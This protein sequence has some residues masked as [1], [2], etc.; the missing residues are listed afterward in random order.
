MGYEI[1]V[2]EAP[3][4]PTAVVALSTT[5]PDLPAEAGDA[6]DEV[7]DFL[8]R[9]EGLRFDGHNVI[10]YKDGQPNVEV[11]VIVTGPFP[12]EG[13]VQASVLPAAKV[14]RTVHRGGYDKLAEAH[15]AGREWCEAEGH[16][17]V[18]PRWEIYG[19]W[20]DEN[21]EAVETEVCWQL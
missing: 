10:L 8:R 17:V 3:E 20:D 7:W 14:A 6:F 9:E 19:D 15:Q 13:R 2:I 21:P 12:G 1:E 5:W 18:G 4:Q 11:G 16:E